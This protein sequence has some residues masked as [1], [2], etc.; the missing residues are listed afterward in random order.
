MLT[1]S[2]II[3]LLNLVYCEF[4]YL[5]SLFLRSIVGFSDSLPV[6]RDLCPGR[7]NYK[8]ESLASELCPGEGISSHNALHDCRALHRVLEALQ[9]DAHQK[10]ELSRE[11]ALFEAEM[12]A[13]QGQD[14]AGTWRD[15][16]L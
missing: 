14:E 7:C 9:A 13:L 3:F 1:I 16:L 11:E 5:V 2:V 4:V 10:T 8:L 6:C 15:Y 12:L